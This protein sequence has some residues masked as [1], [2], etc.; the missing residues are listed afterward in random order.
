MASQPTLNQLQSWLLKIL[1]RDDELQLTSVGLNLT[2]S[3]I[4]VRNIIRF[5]TMQSTLRITTKVLP[6]L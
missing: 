4:Y 2:M 6:G 3:N 5:K 1:G